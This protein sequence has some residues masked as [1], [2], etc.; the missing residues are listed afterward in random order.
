LCIIAKH[1]E[2]PNNF[3]SVTEEY[4]S[5]LEYY[6]AVQDE[7]ALIWYSG[8]EEKRLWLNAVSRIVPGQRTVSTFCSLFLSTVVKF[9]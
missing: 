4:L 9:M 3:S 5:E 1:S 7:S 2:L 8:S 6:I